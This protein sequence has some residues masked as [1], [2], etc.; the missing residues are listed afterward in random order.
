MG[1]DPRHGGASEIIAKYKKEIY[2]R[3]AKRTGLR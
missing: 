1:D 2:W 3:T